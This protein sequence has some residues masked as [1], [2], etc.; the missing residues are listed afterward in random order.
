MRLTIWYQ[1][2][3]TVIKGDFLLS[4]F[5]IIVCCTGCYHLE[6]KLSDLKYTFFRYFYI[7]VFF[8]ERYSAHQPSHTIKCE[9][10]LTASTACGRCGSAKLL[11]CPQTFS[12]TVM[13]KV[14]LTASNTVF[15]ADAFVRQSHW[16][17]D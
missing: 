6:I 2:T 3:T 7:C 10:C 12:H 16:I 15:S 13:C 1:I 8:S 11:V 4:K 9:I 14:C 17:F 5:H